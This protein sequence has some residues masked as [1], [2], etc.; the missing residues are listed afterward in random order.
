[1]ADDPPHAFFFAEDSGSDLQAR[2]LLRG[3]E[4]EGDRHKTRKEDEGQEDRCV[5]S[6]DEKVS[7]DRDGSLNSSYRTD[8]V[9]ETSKSEKWVFVDGGPN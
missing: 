9:D 6:H 8:G 5:R 2:S 3:S 4:R 7:C 1:M